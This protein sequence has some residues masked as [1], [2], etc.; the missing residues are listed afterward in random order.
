M[1][2]GDGGLLVLRLVVWDRGHPA[3]R[4]LDHIVEFLASYK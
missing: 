3:A 4:S 2:S 1:D